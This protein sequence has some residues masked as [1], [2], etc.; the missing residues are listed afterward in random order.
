MIIEEEE[1]YHQDNQDP[2]FMLYNKISDPIMYLGSNGI[3]RMNLNLYSN[4]ERYGRRYYYS[5]IGYTAS[6][7]YES[8]KI[9]RDFDS[10]LSIENL[11]PINGKKAFIIVRSGDLEKMRLFIGPKLE[12]WATH[13]NELFEVRSNGKLY[14][15]T[16]PKIPK[17]PEIN[18][19]DS[20]E[21]KK[22]KKKEIKKIQEIYGPLYEQW[23]DKYSPIEMEVNQAGDIIG[24]RPGIIVLIG[25]NPVSCVDMY[26]GSRQT[27]NIIQMR[28]NKV[29]EL[30]R[31]LR[32]FDI[33]QY[34]NTMISYLG[35]PQ[36]GTGLFMMSPHSTVKKDNS[37]FN[38]PGKQ[39]IRNNLGYFAK[40]E[41]QNNHK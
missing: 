20:E 32:I 33:N 3:I 7:G 38:S 22:K 1:T 6:D 18:E 5:E 24:F 34:A 29:L 15:K 8:R 31:L 35:R 39:S 40:I 12:Y 28:W 9:S 26:I 16:P 27:S 10:Y 37:P 23:E 14:R 21:E 25:D 4:S 41:Q 2:R 17:M 19:N 11:K 36:I 13:C 30:T